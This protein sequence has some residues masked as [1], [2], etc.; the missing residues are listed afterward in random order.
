M[1]DRALFTLPRIK[2]VFV[3][4]GVLALLQGTMT[5]LQAIYLAT[6]IT[7]VF[8]NEPLSEQWLLLLLFAACFIGKQVIVALRERFI[9]AYAKKIGHHLRDDLLHHIFDVG[10]QRTATGQ[11]VTLAV[12]GIR[13]VE[14][15]IKLF[16]P[17]LMNMLI[18]PTMIVVFV[19]TENVRSAIILVVVV[20][21]LI[22]FLALVGLAAKA[23]ADR[24]YETYEQL[25]NHF[26]DSLRGIVTLRVLGLSKRYDRNIAR[27]S[28][29]YRSATVSTLRLAFLS[30]FALEFFTS[31]SVAIV[32]L[33]LGLGLINGAIVLLPALTVLIVAPEYFAPIREFGS[34]YHA[35][36]DGKN[37]FKAIQQAVDEHGQAL[38]Y[39]PLA[40]WDEAS[41]LTLD[42]VRVAD[43]DAAKDWH[44]TA[45]GY[46]KIGII[47]AS[48]AGKSTL[49]SLLGG[50]LNTTGGR[51][52]VND[53]VLPSLYNADWQ[54]QL[55]YIP[56]HP[57]IF[58]DTLRN[59]IAF[60]A[61]HA[62][63]EAIMAACDRAGLREVIATLPH[64]LDEMIGESGRM[65]SGGQEQRIALARAFLDDR[66][67][68]LFDEPTAHLDVETEAELKER[69]LPLFD[70][71]LVFF[72]TH[73]LHWMHNMDR[74][75]VI[76]DGEIVEVG[77]HEQLMEQQGHYAA[78]I[79]AQGGKRH[80]QLD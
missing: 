8:H 72:A 44:L 78:L 23:K 25:S 17:K 58:H 55:Y 66:R 80:E 62:S 56:Q 40:Q 34:D 65:L 61:P 74:I 60:Y 35:T 54:R 21:I 69:M 45:Q 52:T 1:I 16:L 33:F 50:F 9:T 37:A 63:D 10:S 13:N 28:E 30:T 71:R 27:V 12:E 7:H 64:G 73:R 32:A 11:T 22:F 59:N 18:I 5:I 20:P 36:L 47:G 3:C 38:D 46:E 26:V 4:L 67:V 43:R 41:Q 19:W 77:T 29:Q 51:I 57:Y 2:G 49:L 14:T 70:E 53:Q 6:A 31:L 75:I 15:Y 24:Q 79:A 76:D 39:T 42:G 68:L 48:G